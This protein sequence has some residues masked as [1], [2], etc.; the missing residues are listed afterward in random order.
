MERLK[1]EG[2]R[3]LSVIKQRL[4]AA[5][6]AELLSAVAARAP[7]AAVAAALGLPAPGEAA[8]PNGSAAPSS[9]STGA[10]GEAWRRIQ[11]LPGL[12]LM[13]AENASPVVR[14][15]A[16]QIQTHCAAR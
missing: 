11:L 8:G 6:E 15:V 16:L 9:G 3:K 12:E 7:S 1:R 5:G 2:L 10:P 13:L 14:Q 4:D